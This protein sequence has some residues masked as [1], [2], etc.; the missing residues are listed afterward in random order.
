MSGTTIHRM[1]TMANPEAFSTVP[2]LRRE[3]HRTNRE[4]M[5]VSAREMNA[6]DAGTELMQTV[7]KILLMYLTGS[8]ELAAYLEAYLE[9]RPRLRERLEEALQ[10]A[11]AQKVN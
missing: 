6:N 3:L 5:D 11:R 9:E 7:Y 1:P 8:A 10:T 4:L 2:E